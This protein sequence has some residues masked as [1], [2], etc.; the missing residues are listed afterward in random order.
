MTGT[1]FATLGLLFLGLALAILALVLLFRRSRRSSLVAI[2]AAVL[3]LP[4]FLAE[5]TGHFSS[6]RPPIGIEWV[7][8]VQAVV[9][10]IAIWAA[11]WV[12]RRGIAKPTNRWHAECGDPTIANL[13]GIAAT[14]TGSTL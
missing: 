14:R 12:L 2:I 13:D 7:E 5:Q 9:A 3:Y 4:A 11:F 8:W 10:V 6:L 1:G